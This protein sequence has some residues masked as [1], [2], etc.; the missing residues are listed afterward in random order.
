MYIRL[1]KIQ[2]G[3]FSTVYRAYDSESE[4]EVALK[5]V[6][7]PADAAAA[8][9]IARLVAGEYDVL[10]SLGKGHPNICALLDFYERET[11]YVFVMEFAA[12]GDLYDVIRSWKTRSE[13]RVQVD[14]SRLVPQLC[15]AIDYAH[16]HGI[17][18]RDIKPENVLL[19]GNGNVKLAD[20]G[21]SCRTRVSKD[22]RIG[23]EK[24]LAPEAYTSPHDTFLADY[25]SLGI[26][27]MFAMFGACPFK[28]ACLSKNPDNPNF[29]HFVSN[30]H[31]FIAEYYFEPLRAGRGITSKSSRRLRKDSL[32]VEGPAEWMCLPQVGQ[33]SLNREQFL[34]LFATYVLNCLLTV[35]P[36][37][38][39]MRAFLVRMSSLLSPA[40]K[41]SRLEKPKGST[42]GINSGRDDMFSDF[43]FTG[44]V[45]DPGAVASMYGENKNS[46]VGGSSTSESL[47]SSKISVGGA[48]SDSCASGNSMSGSTNC[49][50][51]S[52]VS[53]GS[54]GASSVPKL[55]QKSQGLERL[56]DKYSNSAK[57]LSAEL[58]CH[59][60]KDTSE[61]Q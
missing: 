19:D 2:S 59:V 18:H 16:A 34:I 1:S 36:I 46:S 10:S 21:L 33:P 54:D 8:S 22:V 50:S 13:S 58:E 39:N 23:T 6:E 31:Q 12:R 42:G 14:F 11:C 7:K 48:S 17:A 53:S 41:N 47:N 38:R 40:Q 37:A 9:K 45:T 32:G 55:G 26:T 27:L 29:A 30:G 25:W 57:R 4:Q 60:S 44:L 56:H 28:N 51:A 20:W 61:I 49:D 24:Y 5:I 3:S 43:Y 52:D 15:S 35:N